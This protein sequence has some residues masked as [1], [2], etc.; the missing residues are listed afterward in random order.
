MLN[1]WGVTRRSAHCID[2]R[3]G[4]PANQAVVEEHGPQQADSIS[5]IERNRRAMNDTRC[6][7]AT[8][9]VQPGEQGQAGII[10]ETQMLELPEAMQRYLRY[11]RVAGKEPI[12]MVRLKQRGMYRT[13]PEQKWLPFVAEQCFTTNPLAFLWR[14]TSQPF[15]L[16]S[17]TVTDGFSGGRGN[18]RVKLWSLITLANARGPE[19]DQGELQRYLAEM[20]WFPTAY[21]SDAIEWRAVDAQSAQATFR[22]SGVTASLMLHVNGQGQLTNM[23]TERY[24]EEHGRYRLE[25]WSGQFNDYQE[26]DGIHIPT[27]FAITWHLATGDFTW[28]RGELTEIAYNQSGTVH[29]L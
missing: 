18:L 15:P 27:S 20:A 24:R 16:V 26:V 28:M 1:Q 6:Q 22:E 2:L 10:T 8:A 7:E 23:T 4:D 14:M 19:I 29:T 11:A 5:L 12:H 3:T 9:L 25:P 13:Q 17:I 21:L